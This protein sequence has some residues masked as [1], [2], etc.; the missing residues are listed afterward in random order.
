MYKGKYFNNMII[1]R[2]CSIKTTIAKTRLKNKKYC[3]VLNN[4]LNL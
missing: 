2:L 3:L 1:L 4:V